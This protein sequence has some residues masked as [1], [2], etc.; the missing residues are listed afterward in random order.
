MSYKDKGLIARI[1]GNI[2]GHLRAEVLDE[3]YGLEDTAKE[4]V[5][6]ARLIVQE[7]EAALERDLERAAMEMCRLMNLD[8]LAL[9]DWSELSDKDKDRYHRAAKHVFD[10]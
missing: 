5:T 9:L 8:M 4:A 3:E 10:A 1:A 6:L 2:A 7:T